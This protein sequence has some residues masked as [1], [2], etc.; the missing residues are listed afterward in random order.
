M[1]KVVIFTGGAYPET[2]QF[3][4]EL[5]GNPLIIAADSGYD[6]ALASGVTV[7]LCIGD[8]DSI[9]NPLQN[10]RSVFTYPVDKDETDTELAI[11]EAINRK[12]EQIILIGGGEGRLDHTVSLL[13][14]FTREVCPTRWYTAC[15]CVHCVDTELD[16]VLDGSSQQK[17]AVL[18]IHREPSEVWSKN[19][20]WELSG[21]RIDCS[22]HSISNR[23]VSRA[24]SLQVRSGPRVL[25]SVGY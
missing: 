1:R 8:M 21:Y 19:L 13:S 4:S 16:L 15:E 17:I 14:L 12:A 6:T 2:R 25:L 11:R 24:I 7:D 22:H 9:R 23:P 10:K 18:G 20:F 5:T 3:A